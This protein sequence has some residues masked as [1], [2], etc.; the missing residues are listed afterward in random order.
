MTSH[1]MSEDLASRS[2]F[3]ILL[4]YNFDKLF[5]H[6]KGKLISALPMT[7]LNEIKKQRQKKNKTQRQ[8]FVSHKIFKIGQLPAAYSYQLWLTLLSLYSCFLPSLA[9]YWQVERLISLVHCVYLQFLFGL[10]F[11][12]LPKQ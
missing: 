2:A 7:P 5:N 1:L 4:P 3:P 10:E 8:K 9:C 6:Y 11:E 12:W